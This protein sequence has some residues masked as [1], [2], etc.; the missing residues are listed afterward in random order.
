[1]FLNK[2]IYVPN[3]FVELHEEEADEDPDDFAH[4][5]DDAHEDAEG[6]SEAH[7]GD[8]DDEA[9]LLDAK[10]HGQETDEIG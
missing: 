5:A 3:L 8:G 1:M 10:L 9:A 4:T 6:G 7:H 2:D